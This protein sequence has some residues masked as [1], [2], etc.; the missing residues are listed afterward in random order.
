M[1]IN[2][3]IKISITLEKRWIF[4][5]ECSTKT[6]TIHRSWT[7]Q[8]LISTE[9]TTKTKCMS[10]QEDNVNNN[11]IKGKA[12]LSSRECTCIKLN[13]NKRT[14]PLINLTMIFRNW[15]NKL[16]HMLIPHSQRLKLD[17]LIKLRRDWLSK[18]L[19]KSESGR[20]LINLWILSIHILLDWRKVKLK[21]LRSLQGVHQQ[22]CCDWFRSSQRRSQEICQ[23]C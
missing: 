7:T 13:K 21:L 15:G 4:V 5:R 20:K 18:L 2:F 9:A 1:I 12:I 3:L 11:Y 10:D 22:S 23:K 8:I 14:M 16:S 6:K 19:K 17:M